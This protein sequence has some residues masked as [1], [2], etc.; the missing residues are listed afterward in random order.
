MSKT[1][2]N[3]VSENQELREE[4]MMKDDELKKSGRI[5]T[6][7]TENIKLEV[8][9]AMLKFEHL[10][11]SLIEADTENADLKNAVNQRDAEIERL[12]ELN[13]GLQN[14]VSRLLADL[15]KPKQVSPVRNGHDM[16][17]MVLSR[18]D[19]ILSRPVHHTQPQR[20]INDKPYFGADL[21][22]ENQPPAKT[23]PKQIITTPGPER[24]PQ[25]KML[26]PISTIA[27]TPSMSMISI[28]TSDEHHFS[29]GLA[30]LDADIER[31]QN[32]LKQV[33]VGR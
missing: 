18:L 12:N 13:K 24:H 15:N 21:D 20:T 3:L 4:L 17:N 26:S 25:F 7:E 10:K 27:P 16:S 8:N 19:N 9:Q 33:N 1:N 14:S 6:D 2:V 5:F 31:L 28:S 30:N 32:S 11:N 23:S 29:T 22:I